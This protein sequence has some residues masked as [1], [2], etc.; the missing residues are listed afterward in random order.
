MA[1]TDADAL[2]E[3]QWRLIEDAGLT[4]GLWTLPEIAGYF[5]QRQNRFN[6]DTFLLLAQEPIAATVGVSTYTLPDDWIAT[7]R[8]SWRTAGG[9]FCPIDRGDRFS[10]TI[11][12]PPT[13]G[14]LR[15]VLYDDHAGGSH[16]IELFPTPLTDGTINLLYASTLEVL[17]FAGTNDL[18]DL[19]DDFVP[20][21]VYGVL[22]DCLSKDGRGQDLTRSAY[23]QLRYEEGVALAAFFLAGWV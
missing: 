1:I 22:A 23:C 18:F 8:V 7:Q 5:N 15:P 11:L 2:I 4:S 12:L 17:N 3:V 6:R 14:P 9:F 13:G 20:Y 10:A 16:Q 21:I 19:P